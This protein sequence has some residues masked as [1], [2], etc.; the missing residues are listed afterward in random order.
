MWAPL[1][2]ELDNFSEDSIEGLNGEQLNT[3]NKRTQAIKRNFRCEIN[4]RNNINQP[5]TEQK[6]SWDKHSHPAG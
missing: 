6:K 2:L 3:S 1:L 4:E 5:S